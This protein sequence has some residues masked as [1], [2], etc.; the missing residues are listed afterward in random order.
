MSRFVLYFFL[1]LGPCG[2]LAQGFRPDPDWSFQNFNNRNHFTGRNINNLTIDKHGYIWAC[3]WG[4][5]R[6][7]G[8]R[9]KEFNSLDPTTGGLKNNYTDIMR[10][11]T[12][13][14]W[15]SSGGLCYYDEIKGKFVYPD[16]AHSSNITYAYA[17]CLH[18]GYIWFV[19]DR[20]LSKLN[21]QTLKI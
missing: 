13:R 4:V 21:L 8:F 1:L 16:S 15:V 20:G 12:G 14:V 2:A 17:L 9:T 5:Y 7:D 11:S 19:C 3:S 18:R 6:F 10:D